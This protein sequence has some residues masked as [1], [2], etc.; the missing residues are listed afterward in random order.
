MWRVLLL[1]VV[2]L[3]ALPCLTLAQD[4]GEQA[5]LHFSQGVALAAES[6]WPE[7]ARAFEASLAVEDRPATRANLVHAYA[8][9]GIPLEVARHALA[10]LSLPTVPHRAETRESIEHDLAVASANLSMLTTEAFP[11]GTE[12]Y[13]DGAMP[14]V[15]SAEGRI[16][17]AP[18]LHRL[19]ARMQGAETEVI[20]IALS[21]GQV[22]A[23]PR[24][25]RVVV[26]APAHVAAREPAPAPAKPRVAPAPEAPRPV[27]PEPRWR[28]RTAISLASLGGALTLAGVG[29]Y[30]G[31]RHRAEQLA[32]RDPYKAGFLSS[33]RDYQHLAGTVAPL[34]L[35]GGLLCAQAIALGPR[36]SRWGSTPWAYTALGAGAGLLAVAGVLALRDTEPLG[37]TSVHAPD[38]Q[39]AALAA[40]LA[41]PLLA[42]GA[43]YFITRPR[44]RDAR[45][46]LTLGRVQW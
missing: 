4:T 16:F 42:Y 9:L 39:G 21:A 35:V 32:E 28:R 45:A 27:D 5:R 10:F 1:G 44:G 31:T 36:S 19:E 41:L 25:G 34:S 15:R 24:Q 14:S 30:L 38:L 33:E 20:E 7:A 26:V 6:K 8:E 2:A 40:S 3:F 18:G 46:Q 37:R 12:L 29:T 13:V 43:S 11:A 22:V 23:W 17:L